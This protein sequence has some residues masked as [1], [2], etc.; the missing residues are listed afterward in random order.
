MPHTSAPWKFID[1]P[2]WGYST[3]W[4]P[5]TRQEILVP[6]G[7]NEAD[8]PETWM[9]EEL[10]DD[11]KALIEAAPLLLD[12]LRDMAAGWRYIRKHHGD[13]A[14]VGWDRAQSAAEA[15]I[16]AATGAQS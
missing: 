3:L 14:G 8:H 16:A 12:A 5:D 11:D 10:T 4:N 7:R 13:L 1:S 6:D 9:G 15:A 2:A